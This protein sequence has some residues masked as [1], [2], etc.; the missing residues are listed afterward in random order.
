M[1]KQ[2]SAI[3]DT[4]GHTGQFRNGMGDNLRSTWAVKRLAIKSEQQNLLQDLQQYRLSLVEAK[5]VLARLNQHLENQHS[6]RK[7]PDRKDQ[8]THRR[9]RT[10]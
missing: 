1:E 5:A 2:T 8:G 4:V 6:D 9:D 3:R 7:P 10:W